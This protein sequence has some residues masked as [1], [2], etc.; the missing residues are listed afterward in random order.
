MKTRLT[1]AVPLL[2]LL[3]TGCA[4]VVKTVFGIEEIR[5]FDSESVV[6]FHEECRGKVPCS[7]LVATTAQVDSLIRLDSDTAM[8]QHRAQPIQILYFDGDSLVFYHLG[9]Y[10]QSGMFKVDWNHYGSFDHFPPSPTLVPDEQGSMALARY[11]AIV[12][13]LGAE[14]RYTVVVVWCNVMRKIARQAVEAVARNVAGRDDCSIFLI[15]TDHWWAD[16]LNQ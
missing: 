3:L 2:A 5:T 8:M 1:T 16:Y 12:P 6:S 10:A 13:G 7:Q 9:C 4:T 15:N 14:I 11:R